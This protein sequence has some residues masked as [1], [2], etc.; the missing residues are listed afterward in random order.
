[1][2]PGNTELLAQKQKLLAEAVDNTKE[3]LERL[4]KAQEQVNEQFAKGEISEG[5]Y[6]AFQRELVKTKSELDKFEQKL[7]EAG[8]ASTEMGADLDKAG[9]KLDELGEHARSAGD[10]LKNIG[11][12]MSTGI[13]AP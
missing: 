12:T 9:R 10:K 8:Q 6:R 5:Q 4:H 3:K 13:T 7:D 2:D 1:M 11:S